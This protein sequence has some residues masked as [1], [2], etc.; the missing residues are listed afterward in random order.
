MVVAVA[1]IGLL[2]VGPVILSSGDIGDNYYDAP[3]AV[4]REQTTWLGLFI[5]EGTSDQ[6]RRCCCRE[7][8]GSRRAQ[9]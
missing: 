5:K 3:Q 7:C 1:L 2:Q 8:R 6:A 9:R 4:V